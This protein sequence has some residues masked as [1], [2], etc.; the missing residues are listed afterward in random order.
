MSPTE[1]LLINCGSHGDRISAVVCRH[2]L[3]TLE[4]AV[5]V[6]ENN[7]DPNDLQAW[8]FACEEKYEEEG[9]LTDAFREFNDMA[10]VCVVCYAEIKERHTLPVQ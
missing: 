10:I 4:P 9:D 6:V 5:G 2:M 1:P 3:D 8:C 7:D